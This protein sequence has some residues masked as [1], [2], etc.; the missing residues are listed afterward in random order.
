M[1][2]RSAVMCSR[3]AKDKCTAG[4]EAGTSAGTSGVLS[5]DSRETGACSQCTCV[6]G[7]VVET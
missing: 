5:R 4:T 6:A 3:K 1:E 7:K 2:E